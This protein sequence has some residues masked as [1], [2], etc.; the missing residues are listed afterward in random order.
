M[1][2]AWLY[3]TY[4]ADGRRPTASQEHLFPF[5]EAHHAVIFQLMAET[6]AHLPGEERV[7]LQTV[8]QVVAGV[9]LAY[10]ARHLGRNLAQLDSF[11]AVVWG[12][13]EDEARCSSADGGVFWIFL[14]VEECL[15][16]SVCWSS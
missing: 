5:D 6:A 8:Q 7:M 14:R 12:A 10:E 3:T 2:I 11:G 16:T 13:K 4:V 15:D 1:N 9:S